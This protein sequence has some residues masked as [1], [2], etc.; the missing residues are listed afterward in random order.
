MMHI[1]RWG[2]RL[3]EA[4]R[5]D[6]GSAVVEFLGVTLLLLVPLIY[7]ILTVN[8]IQGAMFAAESAARETGRIVAQAESREVAFARSIFAAELIFADQ[9]IE[10]DAS[11]AIN[12]ICEDPLCVEPGSQIHVELE[13][14][15]RLPLVPEALGRVTPL[16]VP[17]S[18]QYVASVPEFRGLP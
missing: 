8:R 17:I 13:T 15:V 4:L 16:E 3:A 2:R 1:R 7:L 9:G 18:S 10:L 6:Q 11:K 14:A 5:H 12:V